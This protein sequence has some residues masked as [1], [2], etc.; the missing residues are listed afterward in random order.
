MS[1][2]ISLRRVCSRLCAGFLGCLVI[3]PASDAHLPEY[4]GRKFVL[5]GE[6]PEEPPE[7]PCAAD[8]TALRRQA[9]ALKKALDGQR[10]EQGAYSISM[11]DPIGE[12]GELYLAQCNYPAALD[13]HREAVQLLRINEGL[14]TKSQIPYLKAMADSS[15]AIGDFESAQLTLRYVFRIHSMGR[16]E[17]SPQAVTDALQYFER[18]RQI[19]IDPRSPADIDLF[20]QAYEDNL[21]MY[22]AQ[23]EAPEVDFPLAYAQRRA[24]AL[25]HLFN[26]YLILGTD[27]S[28]Y[29]SGG[30][31][32]GAARWD[33]LQRMQQ[34]TYSKGVD[35]IDV[36]LTDPAAAQ[37]PERARLLLQKGNW[38]Q[39]NDKW[40]SAC[41]TLVAAWSAAEGEAGAPVRERLASPAELPED[42]RLWRYLL[43]PDIPVVTEIS[44]GFRVS[45]RGIV[46]RA[47]GD[48]VG[49]GSSGLAGRV[50][51]WVRD[52]HMRPAVR[53]GAC[54]DGELSDRR[55]R[56]LD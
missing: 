56:L 2:L 15:Q 11:A 3:V 17:L 35:V 13:A 6:A 22:E 40:Q 26:L 45:S 39:W 1:P 52:S 5:V 33:F 34:L 18:A 41:E 7:D 8:R 51:R 32:A 20:F 50:L 43:R 38:Q 44:A 27:L 46:S 24:I 49:E 25:S 12:L 16:G 29:H 48:V 37:P 23:V 10:R 53:D 19:F 14:L 36:L 4:F 42:S 30:G 21:G 47:Q 55:Y 28:L 31:D 54:V 9:E